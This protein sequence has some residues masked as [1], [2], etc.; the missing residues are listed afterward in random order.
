[1]RVLDY[2]IEVASKCDDLQFRDFGKHEYKQELYRAVRKLVQEHDLTTRVLTMETTSDAGEISL[3]L[4]GFYEDQNVFVNGKP[5]S[6]KDFIDEVNDTDVYY[7]RNLNG[8]IL[9]DYFPRG[10]TDAVTIYYTVHPQMA[11]IDD[12]SKLDILPALPPV[13]EESLLQ[14]T[15]KNIASIGL[16]RFKEEKLAKYGRILKLNSERVDVTEEA[17][18]EWAKIKPYTIF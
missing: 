5:Y 9:F 6:I 14:L 1:M 18:S 2:I 12:E 13:Y 10:E 16:A 7:L 4:P 8:L 3:R 17:K 11:T 15:L